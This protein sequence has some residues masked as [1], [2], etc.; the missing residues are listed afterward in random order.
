MYMYMYVHVHVAQNHSVSKQ[1]NLIQFRK[2]VTHVLA[3]ETVLDDEANPT[4][5]TPVNARGALV[6]KA[7]ADATR[8]RIANESFMVIYE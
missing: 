8:E 1:N 7:E 3:T 4:E 6:V 5:F 2:K